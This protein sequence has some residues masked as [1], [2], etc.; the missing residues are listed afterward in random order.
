MNAGSVGL[1]LAK[2]PAFVDEKRG[3]HRSKPAIPKAASSPTLP[4]ED[5]VE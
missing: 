3:Y 5:F 1:A 4:V 2:R